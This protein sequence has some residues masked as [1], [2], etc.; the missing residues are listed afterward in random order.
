MVVGVV[1]LSL[2]ACADEDMS[3]VDL[4]ESVDEAV[5][6]AIPL[7]TAIETLMDY[8]ESEADDHLSRSG[9]ITVKNVLTVDYKSVGRKYARSSEVD[10]DKV[11]YVVN[12]DNDEGYAFLSADD[13][14][15][16]PIIAVMDEGNYSPEALD[17]VISGE[18]GMSRGILD[19]SYPATGPGFFQVDEYPDEWFMNPN[20]VDLFIPE[21][22]DTLVGD[23]VIE[24]MVIND[25]VP[26]T[27]PVRPNGERFVGALCLNYAMK[28][29]TENP[30]IRLPWNEDDGDPYVPGMPVNPN[31]NPSRYILVRTGGWEILQSVSPLLSRYAKWS[32]YAPFNDFYPRKRRYWLFGHSRLAWAGCFP[33]AIA[34]IMAKYGRPKTFVCNNIYVDWAS[35]HSMY[36]PYTEVEK[37]SAAALLYGISIGCESWYF[38]NGTF[39]FPSKAKSFLRS[40]GYKNAEDYKYTFERVISMLDDDKPLLIYAMPNWEIWNS[41]CWNID[42]YKIKERTITKEYYRNYDELVKTEVEKEQVRMIHCDM[43]WRGNNNGYFVSGVFNLKDENIEYDSPNPSDNNNTSDYDNFIRIILYEKPI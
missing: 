8:M 18:S 7:E 3:P 33:L 39:T 11:M 20:T 1:V 24:K 5:S 40:A 37:K 25:S 4:P 27:E 12:F 16:S 10:C 30:V 42:G 29:I 36:F 23:V 15:A 35:L 32:Q 26:P 38:Y 2:N 41:H 22:N 28:S 9:R 43:G 34:K 31:P 21:K 14:I 6:H 13:R 17:M 19:K